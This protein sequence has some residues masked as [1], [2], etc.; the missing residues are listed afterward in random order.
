MGMAGAAATDGATAALAG[1]GSSADGG[2][3][4]RP[5]HKGRR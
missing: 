2:V 3:A 1:S 5:R 4:A